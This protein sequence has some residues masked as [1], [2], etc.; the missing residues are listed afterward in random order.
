MKGRIIIDTWDNGG[1][2]FDR[3]TIAISGVQFIGDTEYTYF[4]GS[5]SNPTNPQGFYQH[6]HEE[7]TREYKSKSH[8]HLGKRICFF[9][10][11]EKVQ[12]LIRKEIT[13]SED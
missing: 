5:S 1:K 11:P 10:L 2:T 6:I 8:R 9:S 4:I 12:E 13:L 7:K 3:Y